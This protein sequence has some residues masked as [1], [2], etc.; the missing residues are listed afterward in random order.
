MQP[1]AFL[2]VF[3]HNFK[4]FSLS[5]PLLPRSRTD[6]VPQMAHN[7]ATKASRFVNKDGSPNVVRKGESWFNRFNI[8]HYLLKMPVWRFFVLV[9]A[10][11]T[12]INFLFATVYYAFCLNHLEGLI[13]GGTLDNFEETYFFSSQTLTTVGYGRISPVGLLTNSIAAFE[14][15]IGILTLALI[16]GTL[17]GKFVRPKAYIRFSEPAVVGP[18]EEVRALSFRLISSKKTNITNLEIKV[19]LAMRRTG[20]GE[21]GYQFMPLTLQTDTLNALYLSW[22]VAHT[23]DGE[24]P[25]WGMDAAA[26]KALDVELLVH[27]QAYDEHFSS[28]IVART[29]YVWQEIMHEAAFVPMYEDLEEHTVLYLKKL[30]DWE[31]V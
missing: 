14:A 11:Y 29:S 9:V 2:R 25:L 31:L 1:P 22:T 7:S 8:Y 30:D 28:S 24:S 10:F 15:L 27:L 17:Y 6:I 16:T 21:T 13:H 12:I 26:F 23:I 5:M 20:E 4:G 18:L 19:T 3:R